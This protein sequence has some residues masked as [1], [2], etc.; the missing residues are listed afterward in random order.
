VTPTS[1]GYGAY[2]EK[3]GL[4]SSGDT[5]VN[6]S[7]DSSQTKVEIELDDRFDTFSLDFF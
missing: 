3:I 1:P 2:L 5:Y 4:T 7:F 6:E